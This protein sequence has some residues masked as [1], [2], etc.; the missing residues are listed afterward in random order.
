MRNS[1]VFSLFFGLAAL[2]AVAQKGINFQ[3]APLSTVFKT[4]Q[5]AAKPVFVEVYSPD[6]HVCQSFMPTLADGRVGKSY[7]AKFVSTRADVNQP[8]VRDWIA[9]NKL[10]VPSLPLFLFFS[11]AGELLHFAMSQNTTD[12]V[13][14]HANNA[15]TPAARSNTWK[16]RFQD[17]E[18]APN[19]LIDLAM[20]SRIVRDT[21]TNLA[22]LEAYASQQPANTYANN[23]N[24]LVTQKLVL[25][26]A[27]PLAKNLIINISAYKRQYGQAAV[28]VAEN[29]LMSSLY[30][31]RGGRFTPAQVRQVQ[32]GLVRVGIDAKLASA[33]TLVPEITALFRQKQGAAAAERMNTHLANNSLLVPEWVYVARLFNRNSPDAADAPSVVAWTN[34]ALALKP[35]APQQADLY[36]EQ[37]EAYR[38]GNRPAEAR[39]AATRALELA[40][41]NRIDTKRN[42]DQLANLN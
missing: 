11:P 37:A 31:S 2:N 20:L 26:M 22:A 29:I 1:L 30:S 16:Q 33:R 27:N 12:E 35:T 34:K 32:E 28:D 24:W 42:T 36:Y 9:A 18:R 13:I 25:D 8:A 6:C 41:A 39:Q 15:I 21:T 10:Y 23:T 17:G 3:A 40:R 19:F 7:N 14:R 5:K 38:R 4:A